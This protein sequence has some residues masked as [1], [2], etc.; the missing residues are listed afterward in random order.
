M[1]NDGPALYKTES[2]QLI[3]FFSTMSDNGYRMGYAVS[4]NGSLTGNWECTAN[5]IQTETDG[6]HCMI[7]TN[8]DG[9]TMVSYH[10]PNENSHPVFRYLTEDA[11]GNHSFHRYCGLTAD[12]KSRGHAMTAAPCFIW[13]NLTVLFSPP[14][15]NLAPGP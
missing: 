1:F 7:F 10:A 12:N 15:G 4:D 8:L 2:G 9:K 3:C 14:W 5:Q 13:I 11:E 6:G